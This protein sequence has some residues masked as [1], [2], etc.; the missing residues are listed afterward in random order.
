MTDEC[1]GLFTTAALTLFTCVAAYC[2]SVSWKKTDK[3]PSMK[4]LN[5][6]AAFPVLIKEL[7]DESVRRHAKVVWNGGLRGI[8]HFISSFLGSGRTME[9]PEHIRTLNALAT[10]TGETEAAWKKLFRCPTAFEKLLVLVQISH[11]F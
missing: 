3:Y 1:W 8:T 5:G 2:E 10:I 7:G 4:E 9:P 6:W 11:T